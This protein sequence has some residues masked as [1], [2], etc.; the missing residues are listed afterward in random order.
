MKNHFDIF[1]LPTSFEINLD[2]LEKKYLE[3]QKNFHPDNFDSADIEKSIAVNEAYEI[4]KNNSR[5]ASHILQLN[6]IDLENDSMAPKVDSATLYEVLE[7]RE[8][9]FTNNATE[10]GNLKK[11]LSEKIKY[12]INETAKKLQ[13]KEFE[14]ASQILI[15]A[16]YFDKT[17]QDL[18]RKK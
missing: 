17:L 8:K 7:L 14:A 6:G 10:I 3:F 13:N 5:R 16:K 11:D 18:K 2:E 12:L 15:K 1:S 9:I 4:L